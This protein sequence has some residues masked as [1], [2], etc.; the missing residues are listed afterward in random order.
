[1]IYEIEKT[2]SILFKAFDP[3]LLS[4][5][6]SDPVKLTKPTS[7]ICLPKNPHNPLHLLASLWNELKFEYA[8]RLIN[9]TKCDV[10][11]YRLKA[12]KTLANLKFLETSDYQYLA[13]KLD[14]ET[15]IALSRYKDVD[16]RL[17]MNPP[18]KQ[19][20]KYHCLMKSLQNLLT[21]LNVMKK[22]DCLL[23]CI[24]S[25]FQV[26]MHMFS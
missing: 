15:A 10:Q 13:Q 11:E 19:T 6:D 12:T 22:H 24:N 16:I 8:L 5:I 17:F 25:V 21:N 26:N 4:T 20:L 7:Y 18:N 3:R 2:K 23:Y 14:A 1:M 9:M